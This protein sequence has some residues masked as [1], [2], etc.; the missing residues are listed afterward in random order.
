MLI[1][2]LGAF[3]LSCYFSIDALS[4][5]QPIAIA[6]IMGLVLI[7]FGLVSSQLS[8]YYKR[9]KSKNWMIFGVAWLLILVYSINTTTSSF[10]DH[11]VMNSAKTAQAASSGN[12]NRELLASYERQLTD[13]ATLMQD[14]RKRLTVFQAMLKLYEDPAKVKGSEYN[15]A[16]WGALSLEKEIGAVAKEIDAL[17]KSKDALLLANPKIKVS[18][19]QSSSYYEWV[20]TVFKRLR[21]SADTLQF[22]VDLIPAIVL[23]M[24]SSLAI[25][26]FLFLGRK[27]IDLVEEV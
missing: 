16:T 27:E 13:K 5:R 7:G 24:I 14:K 23:D 21:L 8:V 6:W 18:T 19:V 22:I 15:N 25:Y 10:Y 17:N 9:K 11:W 3:F 26:V 2:G 12:T 20:A 1:L 4:R